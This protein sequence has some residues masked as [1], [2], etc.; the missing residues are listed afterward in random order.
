MEQ[1]WDLIRRIIKESDLVLEVLDARLIELSRN[2]K[3]EELIEEVGKPMIFVVNKSD[4]VSRESLKKQVKKLK[5]KG[6][7]V[8]ISALKPKDVRVLLYAIKKVFKKHGKRLI[9]PRK[10]GDPK[11]KFREAKGDIVVGVLG[12]PNVGK[13]SLLNKLAGRDAAI[14]S[15]IAGTTRDVIEVRLD[16]GG[17]IVTLSDTAGLRDTPDTVEG[18]GVRRAHSTA[19]TAD[20]VLWV[21]DDPLVFDARSPFEVLESVP[22]FQL[23][24]KCDIVSAPNDWQNHAYR[25]GISSVTGVGLQDLLSAMTTICADK[26]GQATAAVAVRA[27]HR[28]ALSRAS[29]ALEASL[30]QPEL[31]LSGEDVRVALMEMGRITGRVDVESVLDVVFKEFCIGK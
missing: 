7:V 20:I 2:E 30:V 8:F 27:R 1:Y 12:Y 11:P 21:S 18:E 31:A 19:Q 9:V 26:Y 4:L 29:E 25:F 14:V 15:E 23:L 24:T 5:E 6:E 28:E 17:Y 3:V 10:V 22:V 13:S 16:L